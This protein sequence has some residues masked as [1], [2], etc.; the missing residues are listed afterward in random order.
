MYNFNNICVYIYIMTSRLIIIQ[1]YKN[2]CITHYKLYND[3]NTFM[4]I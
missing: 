2:I 4:L 3:Y 1:V